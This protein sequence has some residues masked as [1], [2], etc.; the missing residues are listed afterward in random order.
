[1]IITQSQGPRPIVESAAKR[2]IKKIIDRNPAIESAVQALVARST[3]PTLEKKREAAILS[4][5][6][7]NYVFAREVDWKLDDL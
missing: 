5:Y 4:L 2:V 3:E 1:M 7:E 6:N